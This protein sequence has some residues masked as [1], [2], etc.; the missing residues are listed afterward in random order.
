VGL[1]AV[2]RTHGERFRNGARL[3]DQEDW[4][5]HAAFMDALAREGFVA[6]GGPLEGTAQVLLVVRAASDDE[7]RARLAHDP[8]TVKDLLRLGA[9]TPWTLRLGTLAPTSNEKRAVLRHFLAALAYRTQKA[10]RGAPPEFGNFQAGPGVR[11]PVELVRHMTS[12][13]GY[14]RTFFG[15][16]R[17]WPDALPSLDDEIVRFHQMVGHL[18]AHI[19]CDTPLAR[20][21]MLERLLQ[22]PLS[23]AMTHAGQLGM[24]RRL[25]GSPVPPENFIEA[26]IE[27]GRL[28]V[29]QAEPK[30]PDAVWPQ[31]S[32]GWSPPPRTRK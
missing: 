12:V 24:L 19:E 18:A 11:T 28:D 3:E 6:L 32:P 8:W 21:M 13:L 25:A 27:A 26:E 1:F 5:A 4:P 29:D 10:L 17:Y 23:D 16:G 14:A 20:G 9:I 7:I 30:S 2:I 15:G 22:G 31:A